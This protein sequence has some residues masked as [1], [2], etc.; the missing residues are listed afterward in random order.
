M[1]TSI[2]YL[3]NLEIQN[4]KTGLQNTSSQRK[5]SNEIIWITLAAV[6]VL[7]LCHIALNKI[8][9]F[10]FGV[11]PSP[12]VKS[13]LLPLLHHSCSR[14]IG[15]TFSLFIYSFTLLISL[16]CVFTPWK[17]GATSRFEDMHEYVFLSMPTFHQNSLEAAFEQGDWF[18]NLG[19]DV[20]KGW[21]KN[22]FCDKVDFCLL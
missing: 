9:R 3:L 5:N 2:W 20:K 4:V 11:L 10:F 15:K 19:A 12:H 18:G 13:P 6:L 16:V 17:Y 21:I 8:N 14:T 22:F 7:Y 1:S